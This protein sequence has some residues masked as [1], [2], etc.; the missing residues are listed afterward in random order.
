MAFYQFKA[1]Q[2]IPA[3][4]EEVWSF[5]SS[6]S[7]LKKITP[8]YMG[9]NI[10]SD[11]PK[12]MHP[13]LIITYKV[14]PLLGIKTDWMTEITHVEDGKYFVDEQRIGPYAMWHHQHHIEAHNDGVL[15]KDIITYSPPFGILG[16]VANQLFIKN[17]LKE[18]FDFR[19]E[20]LIREFGEVKN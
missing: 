14:S 9:F 16:R 1:E 5:I 19:R 6:P 4:M 12:R 13:G 3:C 7:N 2:K 15:M 18:I 8:A 10:T 17:K 11:V 20:A